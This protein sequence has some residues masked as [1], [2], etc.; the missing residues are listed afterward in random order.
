VPLSDL[1]CLAA[2]DS[3]ELRSVLPMQCDTQALV[4]AGLIEP[5]ARGWQLTVQGRVTLA[6][7]KSLERERQKA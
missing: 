2:L 3:L 4:D 5:A 1:E 6:N 7:L